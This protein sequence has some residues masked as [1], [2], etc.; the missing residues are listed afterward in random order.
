MAIPDDAQPG[1]KARTV[2]WVH[3]AGGATRTQARDRRR[4]D[5]CSSRSDPL[6]EVAPSAS[7]SGRGESAVAM[8]AYDAAVA[9][10]ASGG[11]GLINQSP[12]PRL[13]VRGFFEQPDVVQGLLAEAPT[14]RQIESLGEVRQ[15]EWDILVTDETEITDLVRE[16]LEPVLVERTNHVYFT[17]RAYHT[18]APNVIGSSSQAGPPLVAAPQV[19][20]FIETADGHCLVGRYLREI[21]LRR[22]YCRRTLRLSVAPTVLSCTYDTSCAA[23]H[24]EVVDSATLR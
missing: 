15:A 11:D 17:S 5:S 3:Q 22:G 14:S 10:A 24:R 12:R 7:R 20:T 16:Q 1:M 18:P 9:S 8:G 23:S 19:E 21:E 4:S 6:V 2:G 13:L